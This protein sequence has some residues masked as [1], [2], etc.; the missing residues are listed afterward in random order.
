[1]RYAYYPGCVAQASGRELDTATRLVADKL[2][3]ELVDFP[4][5]SCCGAGVVDEADFEVNLA[6]NARNLALAEEKGIDMLTVCST[7]TGML[8]R[9]NKTMEKDKA[10]SMKVQNV[11]SHTGVEYNGTTKVKHLLWILATDYGYD[12]LREKVVFPL[13]GLKVASFYG[14]HILRPSDILGFENPENPQSFEQLITALGAEPI[15]YD[16]RV[17]C[18]GFPILFVKEEAA[19]KMSGNYLK[20]AKAHGADSMVTTCPLCHISL[21]TF[22]PKAEAAIGESLELPTL[23]LAQL[24]GLALGLEPKELGLSRHIVSP[25]KVLE[26]LSSLAVSV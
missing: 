16:G 6:L 12:K 19:A 1:M 14:C 7:C 24:V 18:C 13:N 11:L 20:D 5:F 22:Q 17:K 23:H 2:G 21:D 15:I 26:K 9:A 8:T 4:N 10:L 25:Q 3:I